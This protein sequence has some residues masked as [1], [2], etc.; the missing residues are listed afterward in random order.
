MATSAREAHSQTKAQL[1]RPAPWEMAVRGAIFPSR[2]T[3][4]NIHVTMPAQTAP[5]RKHFSKALHNSETPCKPNSRLMPESGLKREKSGI[6]A[7]VVKFQPPK[8]TD[9]NR[10]I[11]ISAPNTGK[12]AVNA[13]MQA[14]PKE[15]FIESVVRN[16]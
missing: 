11:T 2:S 15:L 8:A 4:P 7:W 3:S 6:I 9:A 13:L 1:K 14:S 10:I 16:V 12:T 5:T